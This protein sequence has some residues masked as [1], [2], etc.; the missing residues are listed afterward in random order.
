ML[1]IV[2]GSHPNAGSEASTSKFLGR[3]EN[4]EANRPRSS[5][6]IISPS[7]VPVPLTQV[8]TCAGLLVK[9]TMFLGEILALA[10]VQTA[11]AAL[12]WKPPWASTISGAT[13]L[14]ING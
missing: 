12:A 3:F 5:N 13:Q 8:F 7:A 11:H 10:P 14:A 9:P 2:A 6:I 1:D 4:N